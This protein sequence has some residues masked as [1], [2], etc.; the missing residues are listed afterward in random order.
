MLHICLFC[1]N[2]IFVCVFVF[3]LH[4]EENCILPYFTPKRFVYNG[5]E[6]GAFNFPETPFTNPP[7]LNE[8]KYTAN[9]RL[10]T[11]RLRNILE[12]L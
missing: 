2:S 1:Y 9:S 12:K 10:E 6:F 5:L 11:L 3:G 8:L 4:V 7:V